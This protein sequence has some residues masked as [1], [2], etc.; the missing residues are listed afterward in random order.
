MIAVD[1]S[2]EDHDDTDD[3]YDDADC[4]D[5]DDDDDLQEIFEETHLTNFQLLSSHTICM[6]L[7]CDAFFQLF[8]IC[9]EKHP[10]PV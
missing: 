5:H 3:D 6:H 10:P 7:L 4:N 2:D 1:D 9:G 8:I